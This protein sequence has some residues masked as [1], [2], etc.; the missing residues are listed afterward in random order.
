MDWLARMTFPFFCFRL[1]CFLLFQA[2]MW[3]HS[4]HTPN[5]P[6]GWWSLPVCELLHAFY[7]IHTNFV[8]GT[9]AITIG[10]CALL[11]WNCV[12]PISFSYSI[13][14]AGKGVVSATDLFSWRSSSL[15]FNLGSVNPFKMFLLAFITDWNSVLF[16]ILPI[17]CCMAAEAI[18]W[19]LFH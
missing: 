12:G 16:S 8:K 5:G 13:F 7:F 3:K 2:L 10:T 9:L 11:L 14:S 17:V 4:L 1:L 6:S 15:F 18:A 19:S